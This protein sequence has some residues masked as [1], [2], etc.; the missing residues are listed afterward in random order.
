MSSGQGQGESKFFENPV[1][2]IFL[3]CAVYV[4]GWLI[5]YFGHAYISAFYAYWRYAEFYVFHAIGELLELPGISTVHD[6]I[7]GLCTPD[8]IISL[9]NRDFATVVWPEISN[10]SIYVNFAFF[11]GVVGYCV[12]MFVIAD[13]THPKIRFSRRHN[14]KTFIDEQKNAVNPKDGKLLY[15]H[16]R[17]F[18]ALDLI[19]AALDD[20]VFGMSQTSKQFVFKNR[21]VQDWRQEGQGFWAPTLDRKKAAL[22]LREQLGMHWTSSANLSVGETLLV[23]IAMPR[24]AAT[25]ASLD[26]EAFKAAMEASDRMVRYC[27]DQFI[28]PDPKAKKVKGEPVVSDPLAWLRPEIDLTLPREVIRT[29]IGH[30]P[31]RAILEHHAFNRTVIFALFMQARRLGVLQPAEMRW[32]RFFDRPLWYVL[33]TIGRQAGFAEAAGVLSHYLYEAK[34][35][36]SIVEPKLDKAVTGI[37]MAINNFKFTD[38]DKE[39]YQAAAAP[40]PKAQAPAPASA[41]I[42]P[43]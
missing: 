16:L 2:I 42:A 28:P 36:T 8:G 33:E 13:K 38:E 37:E 34:A 7:G 12:H 35:G 31:V 25:D 29:Y 15:P 18:S 43:A 9:C 6:W 1:V 41:A 27:W 3:V 26:D 4:T 24:V 19:S 10:S 17:M 5:W 14:I 32:L 21:L 11:L 39:R 23:A 22:I 20:P 40:A 30:K